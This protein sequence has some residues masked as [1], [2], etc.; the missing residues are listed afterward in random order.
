MLKAVS[1]RLKGSVQNT[2]S[3]SSIG[4]IY[5]TGDSRN[6]SPTFGNQNLKQDKLMANFD[7]F[8]Q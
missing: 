5:R 4:E 8:R 2:I 3:K 1:N 7:Q 6:T